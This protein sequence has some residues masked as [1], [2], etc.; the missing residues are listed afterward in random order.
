MLYIQD[1]RLPARTL[2]D[3]AAEAAQGATYGG[4][5]F[6]FASAAG[7]RKLLDDPLLQPLTDTRFEVVVGVD[8]ITDARALHALATRAADR[9]GLSAHVLL[10][11]LSSLFHPKLCWFG[12]DDWVR[13]IVGSGNL[14]VGGLADNFEA[15]VL[16]TA[17]GDRARAILHEVDS[18]LDRWRDSLVA[19]DSPLAIERARRNSGAE[20]SLKEPMRR[21]DDRVEGPP[22]SEE[23]E[24]VLA[25]D[26]SRNDPARWQLEV[27]RDHFEKYFGWEEGKPKRISIQSVSDEGRPGPVEDRRLVKT[28]SKNY[29]IE[30]RAR[31]DRYPDE[32]RPISLFVRVL[33]NTYRYQLLLPGES[34]H[35]RASQFLTDKVG[36]PRPK[37]RRYQGRVSEL[38]EAWPDSPLLGP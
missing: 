36:P 5:I 4:G 20:R 34:G 8:S 21:D 24:A 3:V 7:V 15:F 26:V 13:L 23:L 1:P 19:P 37:M 29:R 30:S 17:S 16:T 27:G 18:W 14:T 31:D 6:A 12:A 32:G 35:E 9:A 28:G 2:L 38:R 33:G 10:H 22:A 25:F 11:D